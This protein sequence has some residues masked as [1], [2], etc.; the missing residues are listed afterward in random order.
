MK[1]TKFIFVY[2]KHE[3]IYGGPTFS[4]D[5]H[6]FVQDNLISESLIGKINEMQGID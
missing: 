3:E 6:L 1:A 2:A 4:C 5:A